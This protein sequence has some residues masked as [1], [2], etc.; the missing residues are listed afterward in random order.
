MGLLDDLK[1]ESDKLRQIEQ[2][3]AERRAA[4]EKIYQDVLL[5]KMQF[6]LGYLYELVQHLN[7]V[8]PEVIVDGYAREVSELKTLKQDGYRIEAEK[9]QN[10]D[11]FTLRFVCHREGHFEYDIAGQNNIER[12]VQ[13]LMSRGL[14]HDCKRVAGQDN[15]AQRAYFRVKRRV[16]VAFDF[17]TDIETSTI[18]ISIRNFENLDLRHYHFAPETI[19]EHFL[20]QLARY[21]LRQETDFLKVNMSEDE[22]RRLREQLSQDMEKRH[23][24]LL[25]AERRERC[26]QEKEKGKRTFL[27][28]IRKIFS[29]SEP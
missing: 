9:R 11:H 28:D 19:D 17:S 23:Q 25:E 4:L 13:T 29:K 3:E 12:E 16:P 8:K 15:S 26:E 7:Y 10:A 18:R 6:I 20:D 22:K 24:E 14:Q 21:I 5:P 1:K 2:T 27:K